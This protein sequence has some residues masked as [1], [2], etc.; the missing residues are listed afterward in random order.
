MT[1]ISYTL[2]SDYYIDQ[3]I[4]EEEKEKIFY[5]SW[6]Y[7]C[8]KSQLKNIG[9]F[10]SFNVADE[11][12]F[13]IKNKEQEIKA[14]YN[15]CPHRG[16]PLVKENGNSKMIVCPY[17]AWS[18]FADGNLCKARGSENVLGFDKKKFGLKEVKVE[19][20]LGFIFVNLDPNSKSLKSQ[21]GELEFEIRQFVPKL[22]DLVFSC[23]IPYDIKAN[24]KVVVDNYLEC[25]H[26]PPTHPDFVKLVDLKTYR[27]KLY[28]RYSSHI[29]KMAKKCNSAYDIT[30]D[31]QPMF[32]GFWMWPNICFTVFLGPSNITIMNMQPKG[33]ECTIENFDFF[34]LNKEPS[35]EEQKAIDY[36]YE[37]L[38]PEDVILVEN[39]QKGLRSR[40]YKTGPLIIDSDQTEMSEHSIRHF[41]QM[42][43]SALKGLNIS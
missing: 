8:H 26:C 2:L 19:D 9:D 11:S 33:P 20:F 40:A 16:H 12:L 14:F 37:K 42:Y 13:V 15:V 24:W 17:H 4:Y 31:D 10:I 35:I 27:S 3:R 29:G 22:D 41:H 21:T 36:I 34:F 1:E 5:C 18:F 43:R 38:Q 32:G 28:E 39:V 23:R 7:A 30:S 6:Q 25:Y